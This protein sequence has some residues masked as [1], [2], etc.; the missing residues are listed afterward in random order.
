MRLVNVLLINNNL[1]IQGLNHDK[2][3]ESRRIKPMHIRCRE[4]TIA[5]LFPGLRL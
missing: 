1:C 2:S 4:H 5:A 3:V